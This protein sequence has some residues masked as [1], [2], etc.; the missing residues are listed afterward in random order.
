MSSHS[1][2]Q[3]F[4]IILVQVSNLCNFRINDNEGFE[5]KI[6]FICAVDRLDDGTLP[7]ELSFA[8]LGYLV[9]QVNYIT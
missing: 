5:V 9:V 3:H 2:A 4:R 8:L 1:N 7:E 6:R